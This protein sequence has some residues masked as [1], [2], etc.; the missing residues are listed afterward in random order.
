M[1][2][3]RFRK[4]KTSIPSGTSSPEA[5]I[6]VPAQER[7]PAKEVQPR[8]VRDASPRESRAEDIRRN[9]VPAQTTLPAPAPQKDPFITQIESILEADLTDVFLGM[10][11]EEQ[12]RFIQ[13]GEETAQTI[14]TLLSAAK[15]N[16]K[17]IFQAIAAWLSL[18]PGV[19]LFF[20]EQEAKIKTDRLLHLSRTESEEL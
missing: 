12:R 8:E 15:I 11:P 5:S 19:N 9:R 2:M 14:R 18:I 1:S 3:A 17:K 20:L 4:E 7:Q 10:Q 16:A 13:K 6:F